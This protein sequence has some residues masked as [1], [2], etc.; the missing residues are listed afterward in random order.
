MP[1]TEI[2]YFIRA[3]RLIVVCAAVWTSSAFGQS[4]EPP[5]IRVTPQVG[6]KV[7]FSADSNRAV[8]RSERFGTVHIFQNERGQQRLIS[9]IELDHNHPNLLGLS[10]DGNFIYSDSPG[11]MLITRFDA[12][13]GDVVDETSY[14]QAK[15]MEDQHAH[16]RSI[17]D[18][19]E[20]NGYLIDFEQRGHRKL[21]FV[22]RDKARSSVEMAAHS[23]WLTVDHTL[24]RAYALSGNKIIGWAFQNGA[25]KKLWASDSLPIEEF[26]GAGEK[27]SNR[28]SIFD[29]HMGAAFNNGRSLLFCSATGMGRARW[30]VF[31]T[32]S[33]AIVAQGNTNVEDDD[34][35]QPRHD[36]GCLHEGYASDSFLVNQLPGVNSGRLRNEGR[37]GLGVYTRHQVQ[38][39]EVISGDTVPYPS[40]PFSPALGLVVS[41]HGTYISGSDLCFD[42]SGFNDCFRRE[43][44]PMIAH[45]LVT[46]RNGTRVSLAFEGE[47]TLISD[48]SDF[49][50]DF[51]F[52][53]WSLRT[54]DVSKRALAVETQAGGRSAV[55]DPLISS[56]QHLNRGAYGLKI[57]EDGDQL[58][59]KSQGEW[60]KL[61]ERQP[62]SI[63]Y[64]PM[65]KQAYKDTLGNIS[66]EQETRHA[67]TRQLALDNQGAYL[68]SCDVG[69]D[70]VYLVDTRT[71][72]RVF[73][74]KLLDIVSPIDPRDKAKHRYDYGCR[75]LHVDV[76][77]AEPA[78][79][80]A[81]GFARQIERHTA[82]NP[83]ELIAQRYL[84]RFDVSS[85]RKTIFLI[86]ENSRWFDSE[87]WWLEHGIGARDMQGGDWIWF[88][89]ISPH[90]ILLSNKGKYLIGWSTK[91]DKSEVS[92]LD[93]KTGQSIVSGIIHTTTSIDPIVIE[94]YDLLIVIDKSGEIGLYR[95]STLAKLGNVYLFQ[96]TGWAVVSPTGLYD[97]ENPG[98]ITQISWQS[99]DQPGTAL[100]LG[101]F[102]KEFYT[103][104][105]L[106][107]LILGEALPSI[108]NVAA[109]DRTTP[110]VRIL[111]VKAEAG[112]SV[113]VEVE[114]ASRA[115]RSNSGKFSGVD[116]LRLLR[117]GKQVAEYM[118]G[119]EILSAGQGGV[120]NIT[121]TNIALP[122][123]S[124]L[125]SSTFSAYAFSA[126]GIKSDADSFIYD[127]Q[128]TEPRISRTIAM[129]IGVNSYDDP[130]WDLS[131]AVADA[132]AYADLFVEGLVIENSDG[133]EPIVIKLTSDKSTG[134]QNP[135]ASKA[136][137]LTSLSAF[138][139]S[140]TKP[141]NKQLAE[142][143]ASIQ[144]VTP[145]DVLIIAFSGH[146]YAAQDGGFY[147]FP[148]DIPKATGRN[149][150]P[151][152]LS[153]A[154]SSSE[155]RAILA[156]IDAREII[157]IIDA[158]HSGAA[159]TGG[160]TFRPGPL[161]SREFGQLAFDKKI[162]VIA[163]SSANNVTVESSQI[164]HGLL[165]YA[166]LKEAVEAKLADTFPQDG[167]VSVIEVL[168]YARSRVPDLY[169]ELRTN[170]FRPR[171]IG[172]RGIVVVNDRHT[173]DAVQGTYQPE[174]FDFSEQQ[175][176]S[177]FLRSPK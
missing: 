5:Q 76:R 109:I 107:S 17:D 86:S 88:K 144:V 50:L 150:T 42:R 132:E 140:Y 12:L 26:E 63:H 137:I 56:D 84:G 141:E 148:H 73:S 99:A 70:E 57:S 162:N 55:T 101:A 171:N 164:G 151:A 18:L 2:H 98:D 79:I 105:L 23:S 87:K 177:I 21:F 160:V 68:A 103:P 129:T 44:L 49:V 159:I 102:F 34:L 10:R 24:G 27:Q 35:L 47:R 123:H 22:P 7:S 13:S 46:S 113:S 45:D 89:N 158:C 29:A 110:E 152:L 38:H 124:G 153:A 67:G 62:L 167:R 43:E 20:Q 173:D 135:A 90:N 172:D 39:G 60:F 139:G 163:A 149:I 130:E 166:M 118:V 128:K 41:D 58:Y 100:P 117:D 114:V 52:E 8:W 85:D 4:P 134:G 147:F 14:Q 53:D 146:G 93:A 32:M 115:S 74:S 136:N 91:A 65:Q 59:L 138:S 81:N 54:I 161:G 170:K 25:P 69:K 16:M 104:N 168:E 94:Q 3:I 75:D 82:S 119:E 125:T 78:I 174:L 80:L 142:Q 111:D 108:D 126:S 33:G 157:M 106:R 19:I 6:I 64:E 97:A 92:V 122:T 156:P 120:R 165:T 9:S 127:H 37:E 133:G 11:K 1:Q 66:Y 28:H 116:G 175:L 121:L 48:F 176:T 95:L 40:Y 36:N 72:E 71:N 61:E 145:D 112:Q 155:L 83:P 143:L 154:I 51:D 131:Y 96:E 30:Y 15:W 169:D 77:N 31:N